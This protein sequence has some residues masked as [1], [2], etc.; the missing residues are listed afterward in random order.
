MAPHAYTEEPVNVTSVKSSPSIRSPQNTRIQPALLHRLIDHEPP[1]A[2]FGCGIQLTL[3]DGRT[4]I[5][6]CGGAAV[7]ILG[8]SNAEVI[9]AATTQMQKTSYVHSGAYT[10]RAAEELAHTI[11]DGNPYGL[12]KAIFMGSGSETV[13]AALK[14]ARQYFYETGQR[15][16][17]KF[18]SRRQEYHGVTVGAM[19]VSSN[20]QRKEPYEPLLLPNVSFVSPAYAYQYKRSDESETDFVARLADELEA[21]FLRLGPE[22]VIAFIAEPVIGATS[23]CTPAPAG[24]FRAVRRLCDKYGILLILDEVMSGMGRTG[25][26][27]AFEQEGVVPDLLTIAKGLGGGY[28]PIAGILISDKIVRGLTAGTRSFNHFQ[29]Y[30]AH[31]LS[32]AIAGK[33]QEIVK[34]DGL[35]ERCAEMGKL[36]EKMLRQGLEDKKFVGDIRGRGLFWGIEF[37]RDRSTKEPFDPKLQVGL[38]V[39]SKAFELGVAIYPGFATV[40]GVKGDHVLLAPAYTVSIEEL[41]VIVKT[42]MQAYDAVQEE[43]DAGT[44]GA[45]N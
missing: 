14:L 37:V 19:S 42:V 24:Y 34:R 21:E 45:H 23:G 29:T 31:P 32:C 8:H 3:E 15:E 39:Q 26:Y 2:T 10:T 13:D 30:Q 28:A 1:T 17:T 18:V 41:E 11:L 44:T 6:A 20:L 40:D 43:I 12:G 5:D 25:T 7:S 36:L 22:T 27:F 33:V 35:V 38:R 9:A 16:R 4:I